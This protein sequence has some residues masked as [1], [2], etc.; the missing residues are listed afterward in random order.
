MHSFSDIKYSD[1]TKETPISILFIFKNSTVCLLYQNA[2]RILK[3]ILSSSR[4]CALSTIESVL[5]GQV[6]LHMLGS[7]WE[8]NTKQ[9][10]WL[11]SICWNLHVFKEQRWLG[12]L[13]E[14]AGAKNSNI[15]SCHCVTLWCFIYLLSN[16]SLFSFVFCHFL[17][18]WIFFFFIKC[19]YRNAKVLRHKT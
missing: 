12:V 15:L 11:S 10:D 16:W 1:E 17:F 6:K 19:N 8:Q 7:V 2:E 13:L 18:L 4:S 3:I 5:A 9:D 14:D